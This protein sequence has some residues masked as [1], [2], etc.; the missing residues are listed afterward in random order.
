MC[1]IKNYVQSFIIILLFTAGG[2]AQKLHIEGVIN[3]E[4]ENPIVYLNKQE[5]PSRKMIPLDSVRPVGRQFSFKI[6]LEAGYYQIK[7]HDD[8][9]GAGA[10]LLHDGINNQ[11]KVSID[12]VRLS[13]G[14]IK[15]VN[16]SGST[17]NDRLKDYFELSAH[18]YR[19]FIAPT[20]KRV[21]KA[22]TDG[23]EPAV[24]DSL[25]D[26]LKYYQSKQRQEL[27][28]VVLNVMG[29]S[30]AI[31]QTMPTWDKSNFD[32]I[33]TV[34][35]RFEE[36]KPGHFI[37]PLIV[38]RGIDLK[39]KSVIDKDF[40]DFTLTA[41]DGDEFVLSEVQGKKY[42]LLDFWASWCGPCI[43]KFPSMKKIYEKYSDKLE[44]VS[45]STDT[46]KERW[47]KASE[48]FSLPW[49]NLLD[50][51]QANNKKVFSQYGVRAL[52]TNFL[53]DADGNIISKDITLI[54]LEDLL[55]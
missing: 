22:I 32:L 18:Y 55:N 26:A 28:S 2:H 42:V 9:R 19:G 15:R 52:P 48:K 29:T 14:L 49:I 31:Y 51:K 33:D 53:I 54:D 35:K 3:A 4:A 50:E 5:L 40:I 20:T 10:L 34:I 39:S 16:I 41:Y 44:I 30:M 12:T 6:K 17:E 43:R 37:T 21:Q 8:E 25:N 11:V 46:R 27:D 45:V 47:E 36:Q 24:L 23:A 38:A 1:S 7:Y 13:M